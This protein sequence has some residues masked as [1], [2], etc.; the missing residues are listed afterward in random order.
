MHHQTIK[1][2][3]MTQ[4]KSHFTAAENWFGGFFRARLPGKL[5]EELLCNNCLAVSG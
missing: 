3:K 4:S 2:K 5:T 1:G